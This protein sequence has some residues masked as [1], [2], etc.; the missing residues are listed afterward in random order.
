M[1][2]DFDNDGWPDLL[3]VNRNVYPEVDKQHLGNE[4]TTEGTAPS[5]TFPQ[6]PGQALALLVL[7][8]AWP[9]AISG[10]TGEFRLWSAT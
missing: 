3:P 6:R 7:R 4:T 9:W 5:R 10:M 1:F 2:F 8:E